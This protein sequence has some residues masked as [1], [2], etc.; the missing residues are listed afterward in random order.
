MHYIK[1]LHLKMLQLSSLLMLDAEESNCF[2]PVT[3]LFSH[4]E[5]LQDAVEVTCG[6]LIIQAIRDSWWVKT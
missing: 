4:V 6:S 3:E 5:D 1:K 2:R